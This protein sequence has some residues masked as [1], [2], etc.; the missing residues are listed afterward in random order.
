[1]RWLTSS[2]SARPWPRRSG[3][4]DAPR[5]AEGRHGAASGGAPSGAA[6]AGRMRTRLARIGSRGAPSNPVLEPLFRAVRVNHPKA[7]LALLERAYRTA[8]KMH[9]EQR[10]KSGEPYI[11][12][13]L[14]V[15]TIL[16][17]LGMTEPTLV[18][19]LLHDTVEDTP[20]TLDQV[21]A[22]LR[23]RG[24]PA[25]RRRHQARQGEVR[26]ARRGRDH[27]QDDRGDEPRH[28]GAGDQA[29]RPAAQHAHAALPQAVDPGAQG[30]GDPRDLRAAGAPARA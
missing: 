1:M 16:A 30:Q 8:E 12:H 4:A 10:R 14:A 24:R 21:R 7:D 23:R 3:R 22:R 19:A 29:G 25:R 17:E 26:R 15:T 13:P 11:T 9:G 2:A 28:P 20:Y 5:R 27:P 18:A 6:S